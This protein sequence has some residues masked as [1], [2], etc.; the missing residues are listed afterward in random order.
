MTLGE[1]SPISLHLR[2]V[3]RLNRPDY[4]KRLGTWNSGDPA[5]SSVIR[6]WRSLRADRRQSDITIDRR[7]P[8]RPEGCVPRIYGSAESRA[9]C[10]LE[11]AGGPTLEKVNR[12][13]QRAIDDHESH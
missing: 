2:R 5:P 1:V 3:L 6:H 12:F 10:Q 7:A 11:E 9:S 8:A 4:S 13:T